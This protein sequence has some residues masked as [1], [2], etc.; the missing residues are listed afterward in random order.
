MKWREA[1]VILLVDM[2]LQANQ[3]ADQSFVSDV[4]RPMHCGMSFVI[5]RIHRNATT[6]TA[7]VE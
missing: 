2:G 4:G 3:Q 1:L 5:D 6:N 7:S